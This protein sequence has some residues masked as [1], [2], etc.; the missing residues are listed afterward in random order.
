MTNTPI[1][2]VVY[3]VCEAI[4]EPTLRELVEWSKQVTEN[5]DDPSQQ[6]IKYIQEEWASMVDWKAAAEAIPSGYLS[7]MLQELHETEQRIVEQALQDV[8]DI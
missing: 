4:E 1:R 2:A 7:Y 6:E 3:T 8:S 5:V